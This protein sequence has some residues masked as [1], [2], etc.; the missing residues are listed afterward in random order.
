VR[1]ERFY[2]ITHEK[3]MPSIALRC[4]DVVQRRNPTDPFTY[5]PDV[6]ARREG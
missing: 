4:E 2:V 1:E 3:M 6:A 5:K